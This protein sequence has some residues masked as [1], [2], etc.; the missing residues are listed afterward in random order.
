MEPQKHTNTFMPIYQGKHSMD[1]SAMYFG[2]FM[3]AKLKALCQQISLLLPVPRHWVLPFHL[4]FKA[5]MGFV[6]IT[7]Q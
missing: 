1:Y 5:K 2:S 4:A 6:T 3:T 7:S